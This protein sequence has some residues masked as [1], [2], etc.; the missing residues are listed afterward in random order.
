MGPGALLVLLS[1]LGINVPPDLEALGR[2]RLRA[3]AG[4]YESSPAAARENNYPQLHALAHR[5]NKT[6]WY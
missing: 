4:K 6:K 3:L 1:L 2:G 5:N